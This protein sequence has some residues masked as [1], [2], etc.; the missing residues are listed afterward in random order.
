MGNGNMVI[1]SPTIPITPN[2]NLKSDTTKN[3][4]QPVAPSPTKPSTVVPSPSSSKNIVQPVVPSPTKPSTVV[5]S[6]SSSKNTVQPVAPSPTK[7]STVVPSPSSS[8]KIPAAPSN[9]KGK[10]K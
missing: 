2:P 4:A 9:T 10:A 6:P 1:I 5:P 3:Q 8:K 7:P